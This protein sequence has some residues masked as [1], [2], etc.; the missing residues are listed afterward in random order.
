MV[1]ALNPLSA[2]W[3][4]IG[5]AFGLKANVLERIKAA[6]P[7][8][9]EECLSQVILE[10]LRLNYNVKKFGRPTWKRLVEVVARPAGG[11]N[12]VL[13]KKIAKKGCQ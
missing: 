7:E 13:A 2:R 11:N 1:S 3:K 9:P 10:W 4:K 12:T 6:N 5:R 8:N